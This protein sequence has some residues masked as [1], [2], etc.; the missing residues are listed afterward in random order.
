MQFE[1]G[2]GQEF[3]N[4]DGSGDVMTFDS[5]VAAIATLPITYS[6]GTQ[7]LSVKQ[8][9]QQGT[10]T[11]GTSVFY[12]TEDGT[13]GGV[14]L[15]GTEILY[16]NAYVNDSANIYGVSYSLTNS[17]KTLT[18]TVNRQSFT[19]TIPPL[20]GISVLTS[21]SLSAAPNGTVV[22]VHVIGR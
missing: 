15:F 22:N 8:L 18:V 13:S 12:L 4:P 5:A 9:A 19:S 11:S 20:L 2:Q 6:S 10:T 3:M 7:K 1:N 14:A 21:V 17:N 16:A